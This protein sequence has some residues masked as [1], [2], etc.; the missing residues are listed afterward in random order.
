M[1]PLASP[2]PTLCTQMWRLASR[3]AEPAS[4]PQWWHALDATI[5][6]PLAG[7]AELADARDS[8]SRVLRDVWVRPPPPASFAN[9]S[10]IR[11]LLGTP[12][13]RL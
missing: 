12:D 7:V 13:R 10:W 6:P 11:Y 8:K 5:E 2:F 3:R 1:L 4:G 9:R